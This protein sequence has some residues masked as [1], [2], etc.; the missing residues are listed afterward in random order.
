MSPC[1]LKDQLGSLERS[2]RKTGLRSLFLIGHRAGNPVLTSAMGG[3]FPV[4]VMSLHGL[5]RKLERLKELILSRQQR[6]LA[7]QLISWTL[8]VDCVF[9]RTLQD[10]QHRTFTVS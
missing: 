2:G 8:A 9:T 3:G 10:L 6:D 5:N 1:Q 4:R 7:V